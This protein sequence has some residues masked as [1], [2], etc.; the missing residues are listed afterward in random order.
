M[1][2]KPSVECWTDLAYG[3]WIRSELNARLAGWWP[4]LF[5]YHLLQIGRLCRELDTSG[6]R[7]SHQLLLDTCP[8]SDVIAEAE[9]L[10]FQNQSIDACL[11][12]FTLSLT[13]DPQQ[14][15][16]EVD[17]VLIPDGYLILVGFNPYSTLGLT[18]LLPSRRHRQPWNLPWQ[19]CWRIK[20]WLK[21]LGMELV[22]EQHFLY[23][24]WLRSN[25]DNGWWSRQLEHHCPMSGGVYL[26]IA[27]KR[28]IPLTLIRQRKRRPLKAPALA[29]QQPV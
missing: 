10:P 27:R 1:I 8:G 22:D 3:D 5:G 21:L 24:G 17:R 11:L 13:Q 25:P 23:S 28:E 29:G 2:A 19:G 18:S 12:P 7:I 15:M 4:K 26:L 16:R 6:L 14:V 20:D 9:H